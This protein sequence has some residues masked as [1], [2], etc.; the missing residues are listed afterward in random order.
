MTVE[1]RLEALEQNVRDG[2]RQARRWRNIA[3]GSCALLVGV[4]ALGADQATDHI[5]QIIRARTFEVV[6][7]NGVV[8]ARLGQARGDGTLALYGP[9]GRPDFQVG[10]T[11]T[12]TKISLANESRR[13]FHV[14]T[15]EASPWAGLTLPD[16]G[17]TP[18]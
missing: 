3:F 13:L 15:E 14:A 9:D 17:D 10:M 8:M 7:P 4:C 12:G 18:D 16:R 1:Q 5:P 6:G 2:A 11:S